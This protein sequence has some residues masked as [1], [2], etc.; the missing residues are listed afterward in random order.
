MS[1]LA[2]SKIGSMGLSVPHNLHRIVS[3]TMTWCASEAESAG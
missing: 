2:A 3:G 1:A